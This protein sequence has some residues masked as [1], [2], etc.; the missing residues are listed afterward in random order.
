MKATLYLH[1]LHM[2]CTVWGPS[3]CDI[4]QRTYWKSRWD[5]KDFYE[6]GSEVDKD[7][8]NLEVFFQKKGCRFNVSTPKAIG[9]GVYSYNKIRVPVNKKNVIESG[10]VKAKELGALIDRTTLDIDLPKSALTQKPHPHVGY[11][12]NNDLE[13]PIY[14]SGREVLT[15]RVYDG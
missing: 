2:R 10:M 9:C 7:K 3:G 1:N 13:A 5:I 12:A 8:Q 4:L 14:F 6:L 11:I 15:R